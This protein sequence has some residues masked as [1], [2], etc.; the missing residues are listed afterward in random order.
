VIFG[1]TPLNEALGAVCVHSVRMSD[2][3]VKKGTLLGEA[4]I[5]RLRAG[6][7]ETV[8]TARL[9]P[10][11]VPEDEAAR[12]LAHA[13]SGPKVRIE[14][15]FTGRSNLYAEAAGV[16]VIDVGG[17]DAVNA[18]DESITIAT[19]PAWKAVQEGEMIGTVKIIPFAVPSSLL[20][21]A[22]AASGEGVL[23]V[24]PFAPMKVGVVSTLLPGLK[25]SVVR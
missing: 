20:D 13:V 5:A 12:R 15:P 24:A 18:V 8:V 4:E 6:G 10:G 3:V 19:L 25:A 21:G 23:R 16:L 11:D 2:G 1:S 14:K 22:V 9:E 7:I 17:V